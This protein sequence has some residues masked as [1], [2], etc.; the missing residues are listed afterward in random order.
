MAT[1][2]AIAVRDYAFEQLKLT[3]LVS[4]IHKDNIVSKEVAKRIGMTLFLQTHFK[5]KYPVDV[6]RINSSVPSSVL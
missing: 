2:A 6:F 4:I 5:G 1:E 3:D